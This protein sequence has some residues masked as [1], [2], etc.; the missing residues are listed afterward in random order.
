M[1]PPRSCSRKQ[2]TEQK[3]IPGILGQYI[4]VQQEPS[5]H[6]EANVGHFPPREA[7]GLGLA[8][9][10]GAAPVRAAVPSRGSNLGAPGPRDLC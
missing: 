1:R 7:K 3:I 9:W 10:R 6:G 8:K 2:N 5:W 4:K